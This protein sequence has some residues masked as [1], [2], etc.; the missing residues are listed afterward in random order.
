MAV[1]IAWWFFLTLQGSLQARRLLPLRDVRCDFAYNPAGKTS[2]PIGESAT[3][4]YCM[5]HD[6]VCGSC[7]NAQR[8]FPCA[9]FRL[10]LVGPGQRH[11]CRRLDH[12]CR[13]G[14][15]MLRGPRGAGCRARGHGR[16]PAC[17][18]GQV[19]TE[20]HRRG[21][22]RP[23][24]LGR[25][26]SQRRLQRRQFAIPEPPWTSSTISSSVAAGR[27]DSSSASTSCGPPPT[28]STSSIPVP[29]RHPRPEKLNL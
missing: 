4:N 23:A 12:G 17:A 27:L 10:V 13:S 26:R 28:L 6:C 8:P 22:P 15:Q 25:R 2:S 3:S 1:K 16:P 19:G 11:G 5:R 24:V 14:R 18:L 29:Q 7:T 21:Q 20:A 9:P